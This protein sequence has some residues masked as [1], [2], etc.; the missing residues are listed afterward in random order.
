[1]VEPSRSDPVKH[2]SN[3]VRT[4]PSYVSSLSLPFVQGFQAAPDQ[5]FLE[6][7]WTLGTNGQDWAEFQYMA[8]LA[9]RRDQHVWPCLTHHEEAITVCLHAGNI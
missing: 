4:T 5:P 1:M 3:F 7:E 6:S 8:G 2:L 9:H